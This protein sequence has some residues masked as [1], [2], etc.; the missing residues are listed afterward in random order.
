VKRIVLLSILFCSFSVLYAG[1]AWNQPQLDKAAAFQKLFNGSETSS[2]IGSNS[3]LGG[4][5]FAGVAIVLVGIG[6]TFGLL[7]KN[8]K[9]KPKEV[10]QEEE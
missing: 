1:D 3:S 2:D 7:Q 9:S 10:G 8:K 4:C 6:I 5:I